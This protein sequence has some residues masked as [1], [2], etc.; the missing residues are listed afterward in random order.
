MVKK[1]GLGFVGL[2]VVLLIVIATRPGAFAI[3]RTATIA[4]PPAVLYPMIA[5]FHRWG[6]W[7]PWDALDPNQKKTFDGAASGVGA[8]TGWSGNDQ[9][10]E[11]RMTVLAV[12]PNAEV[13]IKLEFIKPFAATNQTQFSLKPEGAATEVIWAMNGTNDFMGKAYSLFV[14]VDKMVGA[15]FERGL[16][17]MKTVAEG[18]AKR[19]AETAAAAEAARKAEEAA[20]AAAA[21][22]VPAGGTTAVPTAAPTAAPAH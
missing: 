21:A 16:A 11:G 9:V 15:D 19:Q 12:K 6:E 14:D 4:A 2:V 7:S 18:E 1:I 5:D 20:K 8:I 17:T 13:D 10:G 3:T 22:A